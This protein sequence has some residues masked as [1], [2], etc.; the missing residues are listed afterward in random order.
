MPNGPREWVTEVYTFASRSD[1]GHS[2]FQLLMSRNPE[3][4]LPE[5]LVYLPKAQPSKVPTLLAMQL[6]VSASEVIED[7]Y[8]DSS[9]THRLNYRLPEHHTV[10]EY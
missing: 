9:P 2:D 10:I 5:Y 7:P 3:E 6:T 1:K 4:H 8:R